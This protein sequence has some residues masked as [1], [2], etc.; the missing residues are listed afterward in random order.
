MQSIKTKKAP[1]MGLFSTDN[2][3]QNL[4]IPIIY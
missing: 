1:K 3:K 4:M 2:N